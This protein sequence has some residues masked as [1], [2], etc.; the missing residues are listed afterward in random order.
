M[1]EWRRRAAVAGAAAVLATAIGA[2]GS[3]SAQSGPGKTICT[4]GGT[5][6]DPTGVVP[7]VPG[8]TNTPSA[9]PL[10]A[11]AWGPLAGGEGCQGTM[12]FTGIARSGSSCLFATFEGRV[13]G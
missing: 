4:G 13:E 6:A 2:L 7:I 8:I 11:H 3:A 9:G 10:K 1:R 5:P 12:T